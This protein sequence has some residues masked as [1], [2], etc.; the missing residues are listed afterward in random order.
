MTQDATVSATSSQ[1][2]AVV[3]TDKRPLSFGKQLR[4][5]FLFDGH[6]INLNHGMSTS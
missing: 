2:D 1:L 5:E 6:Y 4:S 3:L